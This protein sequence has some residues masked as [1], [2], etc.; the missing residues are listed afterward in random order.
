MNE[1][2]L[3]AVA[4]DGEAHD[5]IDLAVTAARLLD[6]PLLL[7]GVAVLRDTVP[8]APMVGAYME[9]LEPGWL[10]DSTRRQLEGLLAELPA[11]VT[12]EVAVVSSSSVGVGIEKLARHLPP[13]LVVLGATHR[14]ITRRVLQE[15][16]DLEAIREL[17]CPVL[18][19][20]LQHN[21][22][23]PATAPRL[24]GLAWN[25]SDEAASALATA[26]D[27]AQRAGAELRIVH[28]LEP[29]LPL[30]MPPS[31]PQLGRELASSRRA[32][33]TADIRA[34]TSKLAPSCA[35]RIDVREGGTAQQLEQFSTE[36]D[37]LVIGSQQASALRRLVS[38]SLSERLA[39]HAHC[40]L[41]VVPLTAAI[42]ASA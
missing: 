19:A 23:V 42:G 10:F 18:I 21:D 37:L 5:A 40:P 38:G 16:P 36:V 9:A 12:A 22:R 15:D 30:V 3:V 28:V 29:V 26:V 39:H 35:I 24:V 13:H 34:A 14:G 8:A 32:Q 33:A 7:G 6:R 1:P 2:I 27:L 17:S 25:S 4:P 11:D 31:D 41:L 20:P